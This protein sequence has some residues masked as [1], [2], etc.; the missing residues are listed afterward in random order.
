[1][2]TAIKKKAVKKQVIEIFDPNPEGRVY[3]NYVSVQTGRHECNITFCH[4]APENVT[5][6][7]AKA[8]VVSKIMIP[9]GLVEET[10]NAIATN[11]EKALANIKK[12]KAN[13]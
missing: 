9:I 6:S 2:A 13:K 5:P 10:L 4:I 7:K 11:Y 12:E 1:M 8:A 3:S